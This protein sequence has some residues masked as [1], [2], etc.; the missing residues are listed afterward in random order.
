MTNNPKLYP[1]EIER[2]LDDARR[3]YDE[4]LT[5]LLSEFSTRRSVQAQMVREVAELA[6]GRVAEVEAFHA[7]QAAAQAEQLERIQERE[8][9][10]HAQ[11]AA[12]HRQLDEKRSLREERDEQGEEVQVRIARSL[13][14]AWRVGDLEEIAYRLRCGG[15]VD[16]TAV[17]VT[18]HTATALVPAPDLVP[19]SRPT[20]LDPVAQYGRSAHDYDRSDV[21]PRTPDRAPVWRRFALPV[22]ALVAGFVFGG[23]LQLLIWVIS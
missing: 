8:R 6:A 5:G 11:V 9:A 23:L 3:S 20:P 2:H 13:G 14:G 19:L 1:W 17:K 12:L 10:L 7:A 15:A 22:E 4:R 21:Q 16:D 18:E